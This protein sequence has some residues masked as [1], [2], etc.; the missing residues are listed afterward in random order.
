MNTLK[1]EYNSASHR[2]IVHDFLCSKIFFSI[3]PLTYFVPKTIET[4]SAKFLTNLRAKCLDHSLNKQKVVAHNDFAKY[5]RENRLFANK[6]SCQRE[7]VQKERNNNRWRKEEREKERG[8]DRNK[9]IT[10]NKY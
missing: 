9:K 4:G 3:K 10:E 2:E 1:F 8:I 6:T 7:K 5:V